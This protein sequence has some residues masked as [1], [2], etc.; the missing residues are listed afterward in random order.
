MTKDK[1]VKL[2]TP[3][4]DDLSRHERH[5]TYAETRYWCNQYYLKAHSL[6]QRLMPSNSDIRLACGE[7]KPNE[8]AT[9]KAVLRWYINRHNSALRSEPNTSTGAPSA[10]EVAEPDAWLHTYKKPG[11]IYT[12]ADIGEY[13]PDPKEGFTHV[14]KEPLYALP[15]SA[16]EASFRAAVIDA[17]VVDCIYQKEHD[18]DP[19]KALS[20]LIAW[21]QKIALDPAVSKEARDLIER[22]RTEP[23][24]STGAGQGAS[25]C[26]GEYSQGAQRPASA[27]T[28][29][30]AQ[31]VVKRWRVKDEYGDDLIAWLK[32]HPRHS[33]EYAAVEIIE[34]LEHEVSLL[35]AENTALRSE[36]ARSIWHKGIEDGIT[37][38]RG[39]TFSADPIAIQ[40]V[41]ACIAILQSLKDN[42]LWG[43]PQPP[44]TADEEKG[45]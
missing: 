20:D 17:L 6:E 36:S 27:P 31:S 16:I 23:N 7:M 28:T 44:H 8:M 38:L 14:S 25:Q 26:Q 33:D 37:Y 13:G 40:T 30:E 29:S 1:I 2:P 45:K 34:E 5:M 22:G 43:P 3:E 4:L 11:E 9:V 42:H 32:R 41:G 21:E 15:Q 18:T 12:L 39:S 24:T 35:T 19:R 10:R